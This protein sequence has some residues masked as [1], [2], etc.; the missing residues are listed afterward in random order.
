MKP[1]IDRNLIT[2]KPIKIFLLFK[3]NIPYRVH[4]GNPLVILSQIIPFLNSHPISLRSVFRRV[5][6]ISF[7][8]SV[9]PF[10]ARVEQLGFHWTHFHEI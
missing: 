3:P 7:V 8:M 10:L 6:K 5:R 2:P 9:R 4:S 1:V